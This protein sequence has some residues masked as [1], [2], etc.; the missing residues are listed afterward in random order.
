MKIISIAMLLLLISCNG[1]HSDTKN[2]NS[3][4]AEL[5]TFQIISE[6]YLSEWNDTNN[7]DSPAFWTR[8]DTSWV[9][10]TGKS[11][12]KL[13]VY[14]AKNGEQLF[15]VGEP[16]SGE[17][18][19]ARPNG[20]WVID[21][22]LFVVERD[23]HRV[24]VLSLPDFDFIVSIGEERL[25]RPYGISVIKDKD[26]RL[27][28]SDNYEMPDESIPPDSLLDKRVQEYS[29]NF[30]GNKMIFE[31]I[32]FIGETSGEGVI[33][34][35]ESVFCDSFH[36][37]LLISE[38]RKGITSIKVYSL[39]EGRYTGNSIGD[40]IFKYEAEGIAL[41][42]CGNGKGYYVCTDQFTGDNTFHLFNRE[43]LKYIKSFKSEGVQNTD[44]VWLTQKSFPGFPEGAFI[45]VN[46]DGGIGAWKLEKI[47]NE[48]NIECG[49]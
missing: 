49:Q 17:V 36:N 23:N 30:D 33:R 28:I 9:I 39:D 44:G 12:H 21:D 37:R 6:D 4:S 11:S 25:K 22:I 26:Y 2:N 15:V 31:F 14:D 46:N 42:D 5:N 47:M 7:I 45:A 41:I 32:R 1:K 24:Q 20:I 43:S 48:L 18:E 35:P 38:E 34:V 40:S 13:H 3:D 19:F 16:G 10:A 8:N 27:F 29:I